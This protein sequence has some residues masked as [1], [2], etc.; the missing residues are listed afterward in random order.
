MKDEN[1]ENNYGKGSKIG[2]VEGNSPPVNSLMASARASIDSMS[3]L[4]VGSSC[5]QMEGCKNVESFFNKLPLPIILNTT[6]TTVSNL[7]LISPLFQKNTP[8]QF[9]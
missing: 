5:V 8:P 6:T 2:V 9:Y 7:T 3:K 1:F 4:L